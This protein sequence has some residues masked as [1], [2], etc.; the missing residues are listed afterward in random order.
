MKTNE[1]LE[2]SNSYLMKTYGRYPICFQ[3][4]EGSKL[5]D[6][7]GKCYTDFLAGIAVVNLGYSNE[8]YKETLKKQIDN[9]IHTSNYF[10]IESQAK[11]G[12]LLVE[13]S[14]A[15][16]A[17][18]CNS[19]GEANEGAIK[20]ARRYAY[21]NYSHDK[22][23][24]IA[25]TGS[26]HGR[27]LATLTITSNAAYSLGYGPMPE[28]FIFADFND[29][30]DFRK[31]ISEKTAAVILEPLQGEGGVHP[32]DKTFLKEVRAL[33][34]E[35]NAALIFDEIQCGMGRTG[36]LFCYEHYGVEPDIMT[37]AKA[38]ANGVPIGAILA[39]EKLADTF[40]PGSHGTTFGGNPLATTAGVV[41]MEEMLE[42]DLVAQGQRTGEYFAEQLR[43]LQKKHDLILDVRGLGLLIGVE[44]AIPGKEIV[45]RCLDAG[46]V[47]NCTSEK[48]L[49]LAPPLII[50]R[51]E[52]DELIACL[53]GIFTTLK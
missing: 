33:C 8:K 40:T 41:V 27:T 2:L 31:K 7:E 3:R 44:L 38:L 42:K 51:E 17:F 25:F 34:D 21:N 35:Y 9:I 5:Y 10:L 22:N 48:V 32:V 43:N 4:G 1:L 12:K 50:S 39:T 37:L 52:I 23:E 30:E 15:D 13:N 20:L 28:K 45:Q 24:V 47:I 19:G 36:K 29:I 46:F 6:T 18:F 11:L 26:F 14:F 53:D 16:R 49:R